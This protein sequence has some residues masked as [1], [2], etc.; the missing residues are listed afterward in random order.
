M[1]SGDRALAAGERWRQAAAIEP[2]ECGDESAGPARATGISGKWNTHSAHGLPRPAGTGGQTQIVS[3]NAAKVASLTICVWS[4]CSALTG[5][6][7]HLLLRHALLTQAS[8]QRPRHFANS[9]HKR[10]D[11]LFAAI[12]LTPTLA[13]SVRHHARVQ[14]Q[15]S[16]AL[17]LHRMVRLGTDGTGVCAAYRQLMVRTDLCH[18]A[19][20]RCGG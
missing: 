4:R 17:A 19:G 2:G 6:D 5:S 18:A 8:G 14:V 16:P 13:Q 11:E 20:T 1:P 10:H 3:V 7:P 12:Y 9:G 15:S